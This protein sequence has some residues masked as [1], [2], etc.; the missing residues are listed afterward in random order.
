MKPVEAYLNI[1]IDNIRL[2]ESM[3][4]A[5]I[6]EIKSRPSRERGEAYLSIENECIVLKISAR[7]ISS[8]RAMLNG[9][10]YLVHTLSNTIDIVRRST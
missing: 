4:K 8:L 5:L 3:Y 6:P 7:N 10:L 9:Y 2:L 1:C